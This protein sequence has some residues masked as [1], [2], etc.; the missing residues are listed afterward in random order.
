M[1]TQRGPER[2]ELLVIYTP[3]FL[4]FILPMLAAKLMRIPLIVEVCEIRSKS[5]DPLAGLLRRLVNSG[6]SLME[7]LIPT[8][9]TG[10]LVISRG[11]QQYYEKLG[12]PA[13]RIYLL[14]VLIDPARYENGKS[15]SVKRLDRVNY[16]L[17]SGTFGE[18][19]G[20]SHI[21]EAVA[22]V[23]TEYS[24]LKLVFTGAAPPA[25]QEWILEIAGPGGHNWIVFTGFLSRD[26]LI[27][28][29][30]HARGLLSCRSNSEYANYGFPT[31]LAEYLASGRPVIATTVGDVNE[32]LKD[33]ETA[34]LAEPENTESIATA[35]RRLLGDPEKADHIGRRGYEVAGKNFGYCNYTQPVTSF[36]RRCI[37]AQN[38]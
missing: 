6:E 30:K 1:I 15:F 38:G 16:L 25:I 28:C 8:V 34:Y 26:E 12:M 5:I 20:I 29:Y 11:I 31:K 7:R 23:R 21:I 10:L 24:D 2:P 18:K 32:Y 22:R 3:N 33:E 27:W 17:N 19:D 13:D 14:P 35:I 37:G 9:S 36:I 4:K